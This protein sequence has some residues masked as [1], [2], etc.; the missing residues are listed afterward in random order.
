MELERLFPALRETVSFHLV[1]SE[2]DNLEF[3]QILKAQERLGSY[4]IDIQVISGGHMATIERPELIA[5]IIRKSW[6]TNSE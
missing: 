5:D 6:E 3:N 2:G 1:G 4:E